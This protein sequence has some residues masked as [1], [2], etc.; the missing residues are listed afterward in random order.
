MYFQNNLLEQPDNFYEGLMKWDWFKLV[1]IIF[2]ILLTLV[3]PTVL[4]G[5]VWYERCGSDMQYRCLTNRILSHICLITVVRC[6]T[7]RI[8]YVAILFV[9]PISLNQCDIFIFLG[10]YSFICTINEIVLWQGIKYFYIIKWQYLVNLN[11]TF[12]ANFLTMCNLLLSAVFLFV[13]YMTGHHNA[14]LDFHVCT[15]HNTSFNILTTFR[16]N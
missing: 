7:A 1:Y 10:R 9:S 15:G 2:H 13:T 6:L 14:E 12:S 8:A 5:I 11:D 3:A 4:Y 16:Y